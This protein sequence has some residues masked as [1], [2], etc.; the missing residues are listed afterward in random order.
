MK[1]F[2]T[3]MTVA[4][5]AVT[6]SAALAQNRVFPPTKIVTGSPAVVES[7]TR[8][9]P[10]I[11]L[12]RSTR[13]DVSNV[14]NKAML[15]PQDPVNN[16]KAG[17]GVIN[18][19]AWDAIPA[20]LFPS[21]DFTGWT[22]P[23]PDLAVGPNHAVVVVNV[24][25]AFHRRDGTKIFQQ[26]LDTF[27]DSVG[28][29][30]FVFDPKC[31]YDKV[32]GRYYIV[33]LDVDFTANS[34]KSSYLVAVS[35]DNDPTGNWFKYKIDNMVT[36]NSLK[37]WVDYPGFGHNKDGVVLT[38]NLFGFTSGFLGLS[39]LYLKK[40]QI[41]IGAAPTLTY[42]L[43][44]GSASVQVM[45]GVD[46]TVNNVY[47]VNS[48]GGGSLRIHAVKDTD[49]TPTLVSTNVSVPNFR[50]P[51]AS[52]V[53][54]GGRSHDPLDGRIINAYFRNGRFLATHGISK[55]TN[56]DNQVRWYD[57]NTNGWPQSANQ[58]T[59]RQSGN[60]AGGNGTHQWM[61]AIAMN[62]LGD[63]ATVFSRSSASIAP[64][65][66]VTSRR[67]AD[68][69][70]S[71]SP[72]KLLKASD[73][74][75]Y[76]S[77]GRWGDYFGLTVD[78]NDET[79][80]WG[81]GMIAGP[82]GDWR[83]VVNSFKIVT[84]TNA[85]LSAISMFEGTGSAGTVTEARTSDNRYFTVNSNKV[86]RVGEVASAQSTFTVPA[87]ILDR[88]EVSFEAQAVAGVTM[89]VF[90]FNWT[91]NNYDYLGAGPLTLADSTRLIKMPV[92]I[93]KYMNA[94]RQIRILTRG[95][96][97]NNTIRIATPFTLKIDRI[98]FNAFIL[99]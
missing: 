86:L 17:T 16:L 88:G 13:L 22:P 44:P 33:A 4:A 1:H 15:P 43:D 59:L 81:V 51:R 68:A 57:V 37:Y 94:S 49:T 12:T 95:V 80:F 98:A 18:T 78:P 76:N 50:R 69:A 52:A 46:T 77:G 30:N 66:V 32:S 74:A 26:G 58:P 23:D 34:E 71:M 90:A 2:Y 67:T 5:L 20:K 25:V 39:C 85:S 83:T 61:P 9:Q 10:Q 53:S 84:P 65:F 21:I 36:D 75:Q 89:N 24:A 63:I 6:T 72:P 70:G 42:F 40:S 3:G 73:G 62:S 56:D 7:T 41:N 31:F 48:G 35:D 11:V 91:T 14:F 27:F 28:S 8:F 92:A 64:E 38:G 87:G 96:N 99:N 55:D 79:T 47:L 93:S 19:N 29:G 45:R 60:V 97:P 82:S 54:T